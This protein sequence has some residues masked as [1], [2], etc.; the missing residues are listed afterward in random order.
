MKFKKIQFKFVENNSIRVFLLELE[1][2][3][4]EEK[5]DKVP[6]GAKSSL[7]VSHTS[8]LTPHEYIFQISNQLVNPFNLEAG[9]HRDI[10]S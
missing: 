1:I 10:E 9:E 5:N 7:F 4:I 3:I 6:P 8:Y 2:R